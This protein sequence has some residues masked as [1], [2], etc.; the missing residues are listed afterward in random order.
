M[1]DMF[2]LAPTGNKKKLKYQRVRAP[3]S[4]VRGDRDPADTPAVP[5]Q[6]SIMRFHLAF[7]VTSQT[8]EQVFSPGP[9]AKTEGE[10]LMTQKSGLLVSSSRRKIATSTPQLRFNS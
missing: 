9:S 2:P 10:E 6:L 3:Q 4:S 8:L 5:A 1:D 7:F